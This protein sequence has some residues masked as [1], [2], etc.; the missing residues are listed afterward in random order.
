ML[1]P[2]GGGMAD[3]RCPACGSLELAPL[4]PGYYECAGQVLSAIVPPGNPSTGAI[5]VYRS[6][7]NQFQV[8]ATPLTLGQCACGMAAV[9]TC[10]VCSTSLC[11]I[12]LRRRGG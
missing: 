10:T 8:G 3:V 7:G 6:C 11:G 4:A 1:S 5:P 9:A 2:F 12:D